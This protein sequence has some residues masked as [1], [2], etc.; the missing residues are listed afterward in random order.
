MLH[1]WIAAPRRPGLRL[2]FAN[3]GSEV[4]AHRKMTNVHIFMKRI[5]TKLQDVLKSMQICVHLMIAFTSMSTQ[6]TPSIVLITRE[7][8]APWAKIPWMLRQD[9][10]LNVS[11]GSKYAVSTMFGNTCAQTIWLVSVPRAPNANLSTSNSKVDWSL[12][13]RRTCLP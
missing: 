2:K 9:G 6:Q 13:S 11:M 7:A 5:Q 10:N 8:A 3:F 4:I 1:L 12:S